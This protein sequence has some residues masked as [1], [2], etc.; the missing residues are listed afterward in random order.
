MRRID[1]LI[2]NEDC[3]KRALWSNRKVF[4]LGPRVS[5]K[6]SIVAECC[7]DIENSYIIPATT[8]LKNY[9]IDDLYVD[10][11]RVLSIKNPTNNDDIE[12]VFIDDFDC[13]SPESLSKIAEEF[14]DKI[15][16]ITA[17]S[18]NFDVFRSKYSKYTDIDFLMILN[19]F[20]IPV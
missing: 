9:M 4:L 15:R 16:L 5:G 10:K 6:S 19:R 3:V 12:Q 8:G 2:G 18:I 20:E 14:G 17:S 1:I 13:F 7:K 11:N